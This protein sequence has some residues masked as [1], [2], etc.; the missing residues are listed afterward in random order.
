M[1]FWFEPRPAHHF[2]C[3]SF[4]GAVLPFGAVLAVGSFCLNLDSKI[5][6]PADLTY[7]SPLGN[8]PPEAS[9][10]GGP[11][12]PRGNTTLRRHRTISLYIASVLACPPE[13]LCRFG[14]QGAATLWAGSFESD[15][16]VARIIGAGDRSPDAREGPEGRQCP[17]QSGAG[18]LPDRA[19]YE[20]APKKLAAGPMQG[21][22][23]HGR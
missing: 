19:I 1:R 11:T 10:Q 2:I 23:T 7:I 8:H 6:R 22:L 14:K 12:W 20:R 16:L 13:S 17:A 9:D 5:A 21:R 18:I 4:T 3:G 15:S